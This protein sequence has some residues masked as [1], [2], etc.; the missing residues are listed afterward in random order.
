MQEFVHEF[1]LHE[2]L[3]TTPS[4][5]SKLPHCVEQGKVRILHAS[6]LLCADCYHGVHK[7]DCGARSTNTCRAVDYRFLVISRL[8]IP[9]HKMI[10]HY[11]EITHSCT[12][13]HSM[14][15]PS[16][17]MDLSNILNGAIR[18]RGLKLPF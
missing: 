1:I 18:P 2:G 17:E 16:N 14:V 3:H 8:Q 4:M 13:W 11:F 15:G 10:K 12:I 5:L 6:V 7:R 9:L